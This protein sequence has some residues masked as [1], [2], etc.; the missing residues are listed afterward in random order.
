MA[1][2]KDP[3]ISQMIHRIAELKDT[4]GGSRTEMVRLLRALIERFT[5]I[6]TDR[7]HEQFV[8]IRS[9]QKALLL[10]LPIA[11]LLIA[12][13]DLVLNIPK[14]AS[15]SELNSP[16]RSGFLGLG[17][18]G[19]LAIYVLDVVRHLLTHNP[20][21]LVFFAGLLG[22]FF[23]VT[24]RLRTRELTPGEDVYFAWYVLTKPVIGALGAAVLFILMQAGLVTF[25]VGPNLGGALEGGQLGPTVFGFAFLAGFSERLIFPSLR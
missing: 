15:L 10:L 22:G 3:E 9:Y 16:T 5:T 12:N 25:D 24:I 1:A 19:S 20:I 4:Q 2:T 11:T 8:N 23:S 21:A 13:A 17:L 18:I 14:D 6:R 7:M